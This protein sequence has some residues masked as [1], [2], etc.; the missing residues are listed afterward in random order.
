MYPVK[1]VL[2]DIGHTSSIH[3]NQE[4]AVTFSGTL[5]PFQAKAVA[6][7]IAARQL[8]VAFEMG[9]GKT[10]LT[11]ACIE[12]LIDDEKIRQG[13]IICPASIKLQWERMIH[14]FAPEANVIVVTGELPRRAEQYRRYKEGDAEYLIINPEQMVNDWEIISKL[15]RDYIVADEIQWAKNF[16][17]QRSKKL[18]RLGATYRWG[19]TGQPIE[20]RAEEAYSIMQWINPD[21]LG[22]YRT[23]DRA[24]IVRDYFGKP[25]V[26]RNLPTL[27]RLLSDHMV[28]HTRAEVA[29]QMPAV[30]EETIL[31]D[32]DPE[33]AKV[34]RRIVADLTRDV[35]EMLQTWG[36]FSLSGLYHGEDQGEAR[37]RV[38]S[39]LICLRM[40]CDHPELL[41]I[42]AAHYRGELAGNRVGSEYAEELH[43]AGRL[44][45]LLKQP[46]LDC[47]IE[48]VTDI[49][50]ASAD[51][52]IV[53][54]S[55][56]TDMLDMIATATT[57][58]TKSVLFTGRVS[59]K[60]RD[61]AKQQFNTDP[62]T[63]L[64]LS[65]DAG[66]IGLDLP[67]A[68]FLVSVDLPWSAGAYAQRQARIIRLSSVWPR[69]T[70]LSLQVAGSIEE[71]QM[72]LLKQKRKV[73]DAIVDGVG[74]SP[75]G[76][77]SLDLQ[78]LSQFLREHEV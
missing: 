72:G 57:H 63:Q 48:V 70:L 2:C 71:Y 20:N 68:N 39:K 50:E 10:V 44:E 32:M 59:Q 55:F 56:F 21:V 6:R 19:L 46:K 28:R 15:P 26:Y 65:S 31:I 61:A 27:H 3:S 45:K 58:L 12:Q 23:F 33:G 22:D 9:L 11:V 29:D 5:Y 43:G 78:S 18:K 1:S 74:I 52:K 4:H 77:L 53:I 40:L 49:L 17:P 36:N 16:K 13:F 8:L 30:S 60:G 42:S 75:R 64:F 51:N 66:G 54:F 73:A 37:G 47:L 38:M 35:E 34:Y 41:K 67:M 25:R 76:R 24:F 69:V 62:G 14:E 7:M